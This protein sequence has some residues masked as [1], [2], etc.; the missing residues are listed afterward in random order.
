MEQY[1]RIGSKVVCH[2]SLCHRPLALKSLDIRSLV[3]I[4]SLSEDCKGARVRKNVS[5]EEA[6][7]A[8]GAL[9][10]R[11]RELQEELTA[12]EEETS[13]RKVN[14]GGFLSNGARARIGEFSFHKDQNSKGVI[15][16]WGAETEAMWMDHI[17]TTNMQAQMASMG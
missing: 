17:C 6:K 11:L 5:D 9:E 14:N 16:K 1:R 2:E 8:L 3:C 13:K 4:H 15:A 7:A 12:R 10:K